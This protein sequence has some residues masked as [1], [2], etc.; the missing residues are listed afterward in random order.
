MLEVVPFPKQIIQPQLPL[1]ATNRQ[2]GPPEIDTLIQHMAYH[3]ILIIKAKQIIF[4]TILMHRY[5]I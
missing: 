3:I 5:L 4:Q 1:M 2:E